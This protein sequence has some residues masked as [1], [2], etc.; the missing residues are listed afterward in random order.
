MGSFVGAASQSTSPQYKLMGGF[1]GSQRPRI[2]SGPNY[3]LRP[4]PAR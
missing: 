3:K 4:F 2:L 1:M